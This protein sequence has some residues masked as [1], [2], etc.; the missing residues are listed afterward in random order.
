MDFR[1]PRSVLTPTASSL[2]L[3]SRR[4]R[5]QC[6]CRIVGIESDEEVPEVSFA[7]SEVIVDEG[8]LHVRAIS[9]PARTQGGEVGMAD[10]IGD[11]RRPAL[12]VWR[13]MLE[14]EG[15]GVYEVELGD[16]ANT[17]LTIMCRCRRPGAGRRR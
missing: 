17:R 16:S 5:H 12:P 11:R 6:R 4:P 2:K 3:M 15:G 14:D 1:T 8:R 13:D 9:L 7:T 10:V